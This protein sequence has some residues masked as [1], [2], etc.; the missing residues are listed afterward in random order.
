[1]QRS[2]PQKAVRTELEAGSQI[3]KVD[4]QLGS[5]YNG[6]VAARTQTLAQAMSNA[7]RP[8]VP[9]MDGTRAP[10]P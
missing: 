6:V 9:A 5:S 7:V 2:H 4:R 3:A 1:V 10:G 8:T